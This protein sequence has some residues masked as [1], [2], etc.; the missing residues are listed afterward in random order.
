MFDILSDVL[1]KRFDALPPELEKYC[2]DHKLDKLKVVAFF[3]QAWDANP[4]LRFANAK[5]YAAAFAEA[6]TPVSS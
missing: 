6:F 2:D 4:N 5:K 3:E 1:N